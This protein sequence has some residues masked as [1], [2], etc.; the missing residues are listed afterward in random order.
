MNAITL[1]VEVE[2]PSLLAVEL[3]QY[4]DSIDIHSDNIGDIRRACFVPWDSLWNGF[5]LDETAKRE[6]TPRL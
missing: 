3:I 6:R 1:T 5:V 4:L 2:G